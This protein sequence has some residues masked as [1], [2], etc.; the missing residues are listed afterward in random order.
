MIIINNYNRIIILFN[1][2][3]QNNKDL[4]NVQKNNLFPKPNILFPTVLCCCIYQLC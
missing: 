1:L 2:E 4:N 3:L